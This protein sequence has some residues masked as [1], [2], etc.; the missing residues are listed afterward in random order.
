M[1]SFREQ[2]GEIRKPSYMD[3]VTE[4]RKYNKMRKTRD[5]NKKIRNTK[6]YFMQRW[7]Q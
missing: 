2:K 1:K 7:A 3:N 6:G 5:L 4:Q